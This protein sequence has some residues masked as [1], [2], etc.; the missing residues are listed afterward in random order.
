[1]REKMLIGV[2][3]RHKNVRININSK[4]LSFWTMCVFIPNVNAFG[5]ESTN[6]GKQN[7]KNE[8]V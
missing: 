4:F 3:R 6:I 8:T 7:M 1:M 5:K 2:V